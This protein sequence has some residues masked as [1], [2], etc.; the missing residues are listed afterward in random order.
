MSYHTIHSVGEDGAVADA[1][2]SFSVRSQLHNNELEF[3]V[4]ILVQLTNVSCFQDIVVSIALILSYTA[5]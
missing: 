5:F 4:F 3:T 1:F 2:T